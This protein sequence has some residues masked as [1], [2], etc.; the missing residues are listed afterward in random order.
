MAPGDLLNR[1]TAP[2]AGHGQADRTEQL[3]GLQCRRERRHEELVGWHFT[4]TGRTHHLH[5]GAERDANSRVLGSG[6]GV[7][8]EPPNVPRLR[9]A[10]WPTN[11]TAPDRSG[12]PVTIASSRST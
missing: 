10:R 12:T 5:C 1:T 9:I 6:V 4:G 7:A 3:V 11:G 2:R 8:S